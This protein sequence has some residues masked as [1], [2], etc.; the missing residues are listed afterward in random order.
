M[1]PP[2]RYSLLA[3]RLLLVAKTDPDMPPGQD[4]PAVPRDQ[5]V[6]ADDFRER[7][8]QDVGRPVHHAGAEVL[9]GEG[10]H[11]GGA[12]SEREQAIEGGGRAPALEMAEHQAPRLLAG[13][14]PDLVR[15]LLRNPAEPLRR[16]GPGHLAQHRP[17]PLGPR[18]FGRHHDGEAPAA[19]LPLLDLLAHL[20]DVEGDFGNQDDVG[21]SGEPAVQ[22]DPARVPPHELN[23]EDPVVALGGAVDLVERVGRRADRGVEAEGGFGAGHVVVNG[24]GH[25]DDGDPLAEEP[26]RDGQAPVAAYRHEGVEMVL[27]E[28]VDQVLG[29]VFLDDPAVAVQGGPVER[30]AAIGG[31]EDGAAQVGDAAHLVGPQAFQPLAGAAPPALRPGP[32]LPAPALPGEEPVIA[33]MNAQCLP[34]ALGGGEHDGADHGVEA[35]GVTAAGGDRD[36]HL[37]PLAPDQPEH[38][39]RLGMAPEPLLGE[40]ELPVQRHLEHAPRGGNQLDLRL[41]KLAP[42][43]RRQTGGAGLVVSNDAIGYADLHRDLI[44]ASEANR[45]NPSPPSDDGKVPVRLQACSSRFSPGSRQPHPRRSTRPSP[46]PGSTAMPGPSGAGASR[47]WFTWPT[48]PASTPS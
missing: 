48:R 9:C 3:T 17:P 10:A 29:A 43:L 4:D 20:V 19:L 46:S 13:P 21:A 26:V 16:A 18:P 23:D 11:R 36:S 40:H 2:P 38:L 42:N 34:A 6:P 24:L 15:H 30:V 39:S 12:E 27:V 7:H 28:G 47:T 35:G 41:R 5:L 1:S 37:S 31:A 14:P 25:A 22:R 44:S 45:W 33:A 8:A 32:P